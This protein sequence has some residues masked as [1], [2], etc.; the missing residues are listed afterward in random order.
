M[1]MKRVKSIFIAVCLLALVCVLLLGVQS[2]SANVS[3]QLTIE[4]YI[5]N[6]DSTSM[7]TA[8]SS[9][10]RIIAL[11]EV[12]YFRGTIKSNVLYANMRLTVKL[13]NALDNSIRVAEDILLAPAEIKSWSLADS[14]VYSMQCYVDFYSNDS[15]LCR[16]NAQVLVI[17]EIAQENSE[18]LSS[19]KYCGM[20]LTVRDAVTG[21]AAER[22]Y[23]HI[24]NAVPAFIMYDEFGFT[25]ANGQILFTV[26][27]GNYK[28]QIRANNYENLNSVTNVD[29][30]KE[31]AYRMMST[32][33]AKE[34]EQ[35]ENR[36]ILLIVGLIAALVIVIAVII[37]SAG[38]TK[39]TA[40]LGLQ[41]I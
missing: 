5:E 6:A 40:N 21:S 10:S 19:L 39:E 22:A 26:L 30:T 23:V 29:S 3:K 32:A 8:I 11:G 31:Y 24:E 14:P 37:L 9:Y 4:N 12:A 17:A 27:A 38:S 13:I 28:V 41:N 20:L 34:A 35:S 15:L 33:T 25:N 18:V 36:S 2:A 16:L 1:L 7:T